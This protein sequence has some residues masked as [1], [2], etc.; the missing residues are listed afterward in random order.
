LH[1]VSLAPA[2]L[3]YCCHVKIDKSKGKEEEEGEEIKSILRVMILGTKLGNINTILF[4][5][6]TDTNVI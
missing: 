6:D 5:T 1:W 4:I 2:F 3:T